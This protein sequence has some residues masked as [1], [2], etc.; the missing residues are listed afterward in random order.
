M[1]AER[2]VIYYTVKGDNMQH[3]RMSFW[4]Y[5]TMHL[6]FNG[7]CLLLGYLWAIA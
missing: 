5:Y 3:R 2:F 4:E 6:V 1:K 7:A